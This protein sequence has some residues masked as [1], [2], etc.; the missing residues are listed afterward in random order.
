M[1]EVM[2]AGEVLLNKAF[3]YNSELI[4]TFAQKMIDLADSMDIV[5]VKALK[6]KTENL[7]KNINR[8]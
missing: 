3:K 1:A 2:E 6:S 4:S 8:E 5:Y 7:I